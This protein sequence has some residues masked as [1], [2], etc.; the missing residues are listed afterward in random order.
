MRTETVT[1]YKFSELSDKAKKRAFSYYR[2]KAIQYFGVE[3]PLNPQ[4]GIKNFAKL[5]E[6]DK[7]E[8]TADGRLWWLDSNA[9]K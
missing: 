5:A 7:Y 3:M 4:F 1:L 2:A 6:I 8:F 9:A